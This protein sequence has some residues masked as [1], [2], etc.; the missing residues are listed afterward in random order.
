[1]M[2][3]F[4][5]FKSSLVP[6]FEGVWCSNSW[7]YELSGFRRNRTDDLGIDSPS[8]WPTEPRLHVRSST[9]QHFWPCFIPVEIGC[10]YIKHTH[11]QEK[12]M[13][14]EMV[15]DILLRSTSVCAYVYVSHCMC[16]FPCV[17]LSL[18]LSLSLSLAL[19]HTE[20]TH[21]LF[22]FSPLSSS[23]SLLPSLSHSV[24]FPL[25]FSSSPSLPPFLPPSY[26]SSLLFSLLP[27]LV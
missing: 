10:T 9:D 13:W 11:K 14:F 12:H 20:H 27:S 18:S 21:T 17:C 23:L 16:V 2:I 19:T 5:T 25:F 1:M 6:L 22:L 26:S 3:A 4:I 8:L 15:I 24:S 7:E